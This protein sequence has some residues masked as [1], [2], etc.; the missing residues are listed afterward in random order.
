MTSPEQPEDRQD[1][2]FIAD[3]HPRLGAYLARQHAR[4][5]DA[6]AARA[7]YLLWLAA[8]TDSG[9][10]MDYLARAVRIPRLTAE[11]ETELAT[12]IRAGRRAEEKLA[13]GGDALTGE[14]RASLQRITQDGGQ[15]GNRLLEANLWQVV[16]LAERFAGRGVPFPDLIKEGNVG[17]IRAIQ[18]YD[19]AKGYRFSTFATWWIRQAMARAATGRPRGTPVRE[20][21]DGGMDEL[22]LTERWMLKALGRTP[23]PEELAAELDLSPSATS[24]SPRRPSRDPDL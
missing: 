19:H 12:R 15:A 10:L 4:D 6:V 20:P 24:S 1:G 7:R 2:L 17:L 13:E 16:S 8:H 21:G 3:F 9:A 23:T 14:A 22:T 18:K 5:Y 11:E